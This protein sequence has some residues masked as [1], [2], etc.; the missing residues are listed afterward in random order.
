MIFVQN[1]WLGEDK[2]SLGLQAGHNV[3]VLTFKFLHTL[4][5]INVRF[6]NSLL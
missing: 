2:K 1:I 5:Q 6:I 4:T 3:A